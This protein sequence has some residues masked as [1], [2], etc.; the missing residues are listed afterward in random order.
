MSKNFKIFLLLWSGELISSIGGRPYKL[1]AD[2][3]CFQ[4]DRQCGGYNVDRDFINA[5]G[6]FV[7]FL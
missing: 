3:L 4:P 2:G 6:C 1:W 5:V 7:I